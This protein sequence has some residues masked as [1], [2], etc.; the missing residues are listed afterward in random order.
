MQVLK[1]VALILDGKPSK[2]DLGCQ[3]LEAILDQTPPVVDPFA[4]E[5]LEGLH[6]AVDANGVLLQK[7]SH[8]WE[9]AAAALPGTNTWVFGAWFQAKIHKGL[10]Q[11]AKKVCCLDA[12]TNSDCASI[13]THVFV[14]V[15]HLYTCLVICTM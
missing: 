14:L 5:L 9:R 2:K 11:E 6:G 13:V 8:I 10:Y 12:L 4:L 7:L 1:A 15:S 3:E